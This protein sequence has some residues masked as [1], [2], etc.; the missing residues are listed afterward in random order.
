MLYY[1]KR[2]KKA[3]AGDKTTGGVGTLIPMDSDLYYGNGKASSGYGYTPTGQ[4]QNAGMSDAGTFAPIKADNFGGSPDRYKQGNGKFSAGMNPYGDKGV[5]GANDAMGKKQSATPPSQKPPQPPPNQNGQGKVQSYMKTDAGKA[6]G[7]A[8]S[9]GAGM[10]NEAVQEQAASTSFEGE[11]TKGTAAKSIGMSVAMGALGGAA[12]LNPIGIAVGAAV[13]LVTGLI[14]NSKNKK[15]SNQK[16]SQLAKAADQRNMSSG[17]A[18]LVN[19]D[20]AN[21]RSGGTPYSD[22]RNANA[23]Y[24]SNGYASNKLGGVL[25]AA[26]L[27]DIKVQ[28]KKK[29]LIFRKGGQLADTV[30]I[31]PNGVLHE[32]ENSLGD[33]GM[34]VV[35][36]NAQKT[37]C[38]KKYEIEK[39][40]LI[41]TLDVTKRIE[42]LAKGGKVKELGSFLATQLIDNTHSYTEKFKE[43]DKMT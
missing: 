39:E 10:A 22:N 8:I 7:A 21:A 17:M 40:E 35:K 6:T 32:E 12:T 13:G 28:G 31:I 3:Q 42:E 26:D 2:P 37:S 9:A 25:S 43:L 4:D 5:Y 18:D 14:S 1:S 34:P 24:Y 20:K 19:R 36:C 11:H 30:N 41:T 15:A 29:L 38:E 27:L 23:G 16:K 33:K